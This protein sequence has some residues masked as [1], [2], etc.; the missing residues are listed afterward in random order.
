MITQLQLNKVKKGETMKFKFND[1][2]NQL[3][4]DVGSI[5][6]YQENLEFRDLKKRLLRLDK[7]EVGTSVNI[8]RRDSKIEI[9]AIH[10]IDLRQERKF[11]KFCR[12]NFGFVPAQITGFNKFI[13]TIAK[14]QTD[15][16]MI[17]YSISQKED[18]PIRLLNFTS[19]TE[20]QEIGDSIGGVMWINF[21][22][23]DRKVAIYE[24]S[25]QY[26]TTPKK[27]FKEHGLT[28]ETTVPVKFKPR[29]YTFKNDGTRRNRNMQLSGINSRTNPLQTEEYYLYT[30]TIEAKRYDAMSNLGANCVSVFE[31]DLV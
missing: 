5:R 11:T 24:L 10:E 21:Y 14:Y 26:I 2:Q 15:S 3:L 12:D 22:D 27:Y 13:A 7:I 17:R 31:E 29:A 4:R 20:A 19:Q 25:P 23:E 28:F 8:A 9:N 16:I 1:K 6:L 30:D 18:H